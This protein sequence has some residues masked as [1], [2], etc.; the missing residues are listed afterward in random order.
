V[1]PDGQAP[2][3]LR[4]L[5]ATR[6]PNFLTLPNRAVPVRVSVQKEFRGSG[7]ATR[8]FPEHSRRAMAF[9]RS[10]TGRRPRD[11]L[12]SGEGLDQGR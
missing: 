10:S 5:L 7:H 2:Y 12:P 4:P 8:P 6:N 11:Q 3:R 9:G 1:E